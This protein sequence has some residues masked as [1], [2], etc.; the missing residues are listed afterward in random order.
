MASLTDPEFRAFLKDEYLLLQ[1]QYE[2]FDRRTLTIKGWIGTGAFAALAVAFSSSYKC[3][4][5]LPL[6][7]AILADIFWYLEA[8]WKLFQQASADQDNRGVLPRG[9]EDIRKELSA[10]PGLPSILSELPT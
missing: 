5:I 9:S 10:I 3:A 4:Y 8:Y 1:D 2:D 7:V 6:L